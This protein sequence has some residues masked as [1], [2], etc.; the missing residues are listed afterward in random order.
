MAQHTV[1][2]DDGEEKESDGTREARGGEKEKE[3]KRGRKAGE[4]KMEEAGERVR[5]KRKEDAPQVLKVS[6]DIEGVE[7]HGMG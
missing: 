3:E 2:L 6:N 5:E 1:R 4:E 7:R